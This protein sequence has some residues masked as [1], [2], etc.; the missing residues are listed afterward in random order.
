LPCDRYL[1]LKVKQEK[2]RRGEKPKDRSG[3]NQP[4]TFKFHGRTVRI[5]GCRK[6]TEDEMA[7]VDAVPSALELLQASRQE[8]HEYQN[9]Q[10][11]GVEDDYDDEDDEEEQYVTTEEV[12]PTSQI[13]VLASAP[14]DGS[15]ITEVPIHVGRQNVVQTFQTIQM[16]PAIAQ[17][18]QGPRTIVLNNPSTSSPREVYLAVQNMRGEYIKLEKA[19]Q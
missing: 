4:G 18:V 1:F 2:E 5:Y 13:R 6:L 7:E 3:W 12:Y 19:T 16:T 10:D 15:G 11:E 17:H 8:E 9:P 14:I